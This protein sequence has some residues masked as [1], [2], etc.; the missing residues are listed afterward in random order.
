MRFLA[1]ALLLAGTA[2]ANDVPLKEY[3]DMRFGEQDLRIEQAK[4]SARQAILKYESDVDGRLFLLNEF[5]RTTAET[6]AAYVRIEQLESAKERVAALESSRD[7]VYGAILL[8]GL[9]GI[10]NLVKAF[11]GVRA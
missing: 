9:I 10:A 5:Q 11:G 7:R 8:I 3:V 2:Q 1:L 6:A 4:E